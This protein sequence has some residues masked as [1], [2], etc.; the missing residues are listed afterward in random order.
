[1]GSQLPIRPDFLRQPNEAEQFCK[2]YGVVALD[3]SDIEAEV[4]ENQVIPQ[5]VPF[6]L[7][8]REEFPGDAQVWLTKRGFKRCCR[9]LRRIRSCRW[10]G[11]WGGALIVSVICGVCTGVIS[12][13]LSGLIDLAVKVA[14]VR[15]GLVFFTFFSVGFAIY[16]L[17]AAVKR[18]RRLY[19]PWPCDRDHPDNDR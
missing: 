1:M 13:I 16:L 11:Y 9:H 5:D 12:L 19:V 18:Y 3:S 2:R 17:C 10:Y 14:D 15:Y 4:R 6:R 7:T 8:Y